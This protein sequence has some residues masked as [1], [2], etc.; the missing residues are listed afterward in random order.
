[1]PLRPAW[2]VARIPSGE[3]TRDQA[4]HRSEKP[5]GRKTVPPPE[6]SRR[7]WSPH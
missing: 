7:R 1:M 3:E 2:T 5:K 6:R 4:V